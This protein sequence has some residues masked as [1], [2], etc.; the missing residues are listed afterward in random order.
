MLFI[1]RQLR[2]LELRK[3]SGQYFL[4]AFGEI[5]LVVVGI[6]VALQIN[7]WNEER[8][9]KNERRQLIEKLEY[10][11]RVNLPRIDESIELAEERNEGLRS[12]LSA[13]GTRNEAVSVNDLKTLVLNGFS[14][15]G[16]PPN[17][18]SY[19]TA[20]NTGTINLIEDP[21]LSDLFTT[22]ED[23]VSTY[24][25][26]VDINRDD[27]LTGMSAKVRGELGSFGLLFPEERSMYLGHPLADQT[28]F[29]ISDEAFREFLSRKHVY[30]A[31]ENRL[32]IRSRISS[33]QHRV[34]ETMEEIL[35]RLEEL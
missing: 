33:T 2:R 24:T 9:L 34:K 31:F 10:D 17:I 27:V 4:Y 18:N 25:E 35:A 22:F 30:S 3:R 32:I 12:F 26:L 15:L 8:K 14:G 21:V 1:L 13:V 23:R 28:I 20:V 11:F 29:Q 16:V 6:L 19:N 5:V 7:N